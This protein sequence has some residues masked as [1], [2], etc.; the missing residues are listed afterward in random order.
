MRSG[1][2]LGAMGPMKWRQP[3]LADMHPWLPP[4]KGPC[5]PG[6]PVVPLPVGGPEEGGGGLQAAGFFWQGPPGP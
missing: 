1:W 5:G 4:L 2:G 6:L 3:G